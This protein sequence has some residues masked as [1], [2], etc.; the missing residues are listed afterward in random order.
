MALDDPGGGMLEAHMQDESVP[1]ASDRATEW[2][3]N[4]AACIALAMIP[5]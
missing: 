2:S 1:S 4:T 5:A 3:Q